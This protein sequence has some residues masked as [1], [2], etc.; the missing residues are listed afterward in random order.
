MLKTKFELFMRSLLK[1][2]SVALHL[3]VISDASS[4][5]GAEEILRK[6][7]PA[8][9]ASIVQYTIYNVSVIASR[10]SDITNSMMPYFSVPGNLRIDTLNV[11]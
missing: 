5:L 11:I 2:S 9:K 10:L 8:Y 7:I 3:H 1:Y 6:Q 4:E